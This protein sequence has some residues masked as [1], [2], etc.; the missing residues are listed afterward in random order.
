VET[1]VM[2]DRSASQTSL[3]RQLVRRIRSAALAT[4]DAQ[5]APF[6]SLVI[7]APASDGTP[8]M[9][10]ST[11]AV[12]TRN[13]ERDPR[14][15]LLVVG[16]PAGEGS[17]VTAPR[18]SLLGRVLPDASPESRSRY[19]AVHPDASLYA[20]FADFAVY[21]FEIASA[22]LVAGFGR[23]VDLGASELLSADP[24]ES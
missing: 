1:F 2:P 9:L 12:H 22:H 20:D 11:L 19:L 24:P 4:V 16:E 7:I 8:L 6:A 23:I 13:I 18:L 10:L 15:S 3:A 14:A 5:G 17:A 21:R